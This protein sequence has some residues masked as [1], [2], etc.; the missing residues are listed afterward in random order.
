MKTIGTIFLIALILITLTSTA[1]AQ[2]MEKRHQL[3]L[4]I[5]MWNQT[6]EVRTE[7]YGSVDVSVDNNG[8]LGGIAYGH[9]LKEYLALYIGVSS[10]AAD[11][12]TE[13]SV[14]QVSSETGYVTPLLFGMKYYFLPSTYQSSIK[15]Y[16]KGGIGPFFGSQSQTTV[17]LVVVVEERTETAFGGQLGAGIDFILSP[18]FMAGISGGYNFMSDFEQPIGGSVNYGGPEFSINLSY[19]FGQGM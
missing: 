2:P 15:P 14:L 4:R 19:L 18:H 13:V 16:F 8:L 11:I 17:S 9:W 6:A 3:E 5:G 10:L 1:G 12:R 7:T